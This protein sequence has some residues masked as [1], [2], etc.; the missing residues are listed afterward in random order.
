MNTI[1]SND[2][3]QRYSKYQKP[4]YQSQPKTK[5]QTQ[6]QRK[7]NSIRKQQKPKYQPQYRRKPNRR[8]LPYQQKLKKQQQT[9]S[10]NKNRNDRSQRYSKYQ[11]PTYQ[12]QPKT[13]SQTQ[14]QRKTNSISKQ[15]RPKYVS[16]YK[17]TLQQNRNTGTNKSRNYQKKISKID[18]E[19]LLGLENQISYMF[20]Q[21]IYERK[22][23][24]T[25]NQNKN[26]MYLETTTK[27]RKNLE[28]EK[29]D[30]IKDDHVGHIIA[31]SNGGINHEKNF[32]MTSRKINKPLLNNYDHINCALAG[33]ER[34]KQAITL[35]KKIGNISKKT[36]EKN[37]VKRYNGYSAKKMVNLGKRD[38]KK[39]GVLTKKGGGIDKRSKAVR[40]QDIRFNKDG[41][42]RK[43]CKFLND[44]EKNLEIKATKYIPNYISYDTP[45][46]YQNYLTDNYNCSYFPESN[47]ITYNN[48]SF[49]NYDLISIL[50]DY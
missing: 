1:S 22:N 49:N 34:T 12:S 5:R 20:P 21:E 36:I 3:S 2:R 14:T 19:T 47:T 7:T 10:N 43:N 38:L 31:K 33:E 26:K 30:Y 37:N 29:R 25:I 13:K 27:F 41:R 17:Q 6:T 35:S 9:N 46:L 23:Q 28:L 4:N 16:Q 11:K 32:M 39:M 15:Q 40:N 44:F 18:S 50:L 42:M 45:D 24:E 8:P 48:P